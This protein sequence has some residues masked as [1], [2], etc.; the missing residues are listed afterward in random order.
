M[1]EDDGETLK[2]SPVDDLVATRN[3]LYDRNFTDR[4]LD[5][6]TITSTL[7][8]EVKLPFGISYRA[9]YT[10]HFTMDRYFNHQSSGHQEWGLFGGQVNREH[11]ETFAWQLDNIIKWE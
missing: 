9:N 2:L 3:P 4:M 1:Y 11:A 7:F 10:P 5:I 6:T 8:A